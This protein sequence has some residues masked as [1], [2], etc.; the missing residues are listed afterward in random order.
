MSRR[1]IFSLGLVA[2]FALVLVACGPKLPDGCPPDC[3]GLY[4]YQ[5][6]LGKVDLSGADFH[7]TDLSRANLVG[8]KLS[9]ANLQNAGLRYADLRGADLTNA[10]LRGADLR[11]AR[12]KGADLTGANLE[13][14]NL[15]LSTY[16]PDTIWPEGFDQKAAGAVL[17]AE[18]FGR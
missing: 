10:D 8:A 7:D 18:D 11:F 13:G 5:Y 4:L 14:A 17:A 1:V 15:L 6:K 12:L 3:D 9:G 16:R 2:I